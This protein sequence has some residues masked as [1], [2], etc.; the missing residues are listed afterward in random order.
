MIRKNVAKKIKNRFIEISELPEEL[1]TGYSKMVLLGD[2]EF[3]I[4]NS[5]GII[6]YDNNKI[7]VNTLSGIIEVLG[8]KL[9]INE[10][11]SK[12]LLVKGKIKNIGIE[13][14]S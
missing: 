12:E 9:I 5:H 8:E 11:S 6:E 3:L 13:N 7:R 14:N 2:K 10:I 4:E 1:L